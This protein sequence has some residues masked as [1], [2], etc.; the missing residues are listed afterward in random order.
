M[1]PA[2][3]DRHVRAF[4][5]LRGIAIALVLL[6]HL[7]EDLPARRLGG[8]VDAALNAGWL[9]VDVFFVLSGFLIT[10]ILLDARGDEAQPSE[11]YFQRFYA[12]RALRI[13]PL[14]YLFLA[15][16]IFIA[17][18]PMPHG[19]WWYWSY[20]SNVLIARHGWPEG[21]WETGH[22]WSLAVEEQFYLVWPAIIAW[23]PRRRLPVLC[24]AIIVSAI[25]MR[26]ALIHQS[27]ALGAYVLTPARADTLAVGATLAIALR[28]GARVKAAIARGSPMIAVAA[29]VVL[30]VLFATHRLDHRL[31]IGGL[32][33]GSLATTLLTAAC[34]GRIET[35]AWLRRMLEWRLLV[36]FGTYS[37]AIYLVQLPL[38]GGIDYW[39][40]ARFAAWPA[41][42]GVGAEAMLLA[43]GSWCIAWASWRLIERPILSLKRYV[44]MPRLTD[45]RVG[46]IGSTGLGTTM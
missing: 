39:L 3:A 26:I 40:G 44:P 12:R 41:T 21:F 14:Y 31:T 23:T 27:A 43:G 13:F 46:M 7:G 20:V 1:R 34:I 30:A 10:G 15:V 8:M 33:L 24:V 11:G 42:I 29:I 35:T 18:P 19:T 22:L 5:G 32:V 36:S 17:R 38:R 2:A 45:A 25:A 37:Y 28:S 16:T 6:R 9:G 4:D